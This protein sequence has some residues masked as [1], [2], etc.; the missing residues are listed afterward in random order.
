MGVTEK[1]MLAMPRG[2]KWAVLN[3]LYCVPQSAIKRMRMKP[4]YS[5]VQRLPYNLLGTASQ[6]NNIYSINRAGME[7]CMWTIKWLRSWE[8]VEAGI[9]QYV[10]IQ[11]REKYR[12]ELLL[13]NSFIK[14]TGKLW[15][16]KKKAGNTFGKDP[17]KSSQVPKLWEMLE[18]WD[19]CQVSSTGQCSEEVTLL[20]KIKCCLIHNCDSALLLAHIWLC[21][22][23]F[24]I[25]TR[26]PS[27]T[28]RSCP[29]SEAGIS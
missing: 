11:S 14:H 16:K 26:G 15:G 19:G 2:W 5:E 20:I 29:F 23:P 4:S 24:W 25:Q 8:L 12:K 10:M 18:R 22:N 9:N 3:E 1:F 27:H 7:F 17:R 13:R 6:D 21:L 28:W